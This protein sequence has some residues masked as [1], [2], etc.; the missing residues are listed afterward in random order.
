MIVDSQCHWFSPTLL[1][2]LLDLDDYPRCRRD[3]DGYA[4]EVAP[5]R[6][7]P[8]GARFTD[9][10]SQLEMFAAA[11]VD[12]VISS[13]GSFGDVD[14]LEPGRAGEVAHAVNAERAAAEQANPGRFYGL[15]TLPWQDTDAALAALDDAVVHLGLRGV[16]VHSNINGAPIDSDTCRPVYARIAEL[17]RAALPSSHSLARRGA[18]PRLRPRVP[19]RLRVRHEPRR[20]AAG[21]QRHRRGEP[22]P[23]GRAAALRW[24]A[25]LPRGPHRRVAREA[26]LARTTPRPAPER[27]APR[28][29][30]R[31]RVAGRGHA[32]LRR[33]ILRRRAPDVR[34][35]LPVL[36][37]RGAARVRPRPRAGR[38]FSAGTRRRCSVWPR[39]SSR[40]SHRIGSP[41]W[42]ISTSSSVAQSGQKNS[43]QTNESPPMPCGSTHGPAFWTG[44]SRTTV[45][46]L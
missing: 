34:Q 40:T 10:E 32:R 2:A 24:D 19:R 22:G 23:D 3:G 25:P 37:G 7:V 8:W 4:F 18:T 14:R 16:L 41:R 13:S 5:G 43:R 44:P 35:R 20:P 21:A 39:A 15:A 46:S 29:L 28:L 27:A 38:R 33:R 42:A 17:G 26:V 31:H 12:T 6:F 1:D 45:C 11:G 9:L 30:H 36:L